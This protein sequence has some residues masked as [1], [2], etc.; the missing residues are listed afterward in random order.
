MLETLKNIFTGAETRKKILI[1]LA[2]LAVSRFLAALPCPGIDR[3]M[4]SQ[5]AAS[6]DMKALGFLNLFAGN[7][8]SNLAIGAVGITAYINASI[9]IQLL[10]AVVPYLNELTKIGKEGTD[11]IKRITFILSVAI[12]FVQGLSYSLRFRNYGVIGQSWQSAAEVTFFLTLGSV[13][14]YGISEL[15]EH[16]GIGNGVSFIIAVNIATGLYTS[17]GEIWNVFIKGQNPVRGTVNGMIAVAVV[18]A[19]MYAIIYYNDGEKRLGVTYPGSNRYTASMKTYLPIKPS[20]GNVMPPI[21]ALSFFQLLGAV[22]TVAGDHP[23]TVPFR[24]FQQS[25]WFDFSG[26]WTWLYSLGVILY[27][28]MIVG[29][30]YLYAKI[31]F[32]PQEVADNLRMQGGM[33]NGI[34]QDK[35]A[36]EIERQSSG[37]LLIGGLG[38][39]VIM[40]LPTLIAK[41]INIG[42]LAV[43]GTSLIILVS[44]ASDIASRITADAKI[45]SDRKMSFRGKGR[46]FNV[47]AD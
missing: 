33:L 6:S 37:A 29:C 10:S 40:I 16:R 26:K 8:L 4:L 23:W 9:I 17:A 30:T 1:T 27:V 44:V 47:K 38:I 11:K 15:I 3:T 19:V 20:V 24:I 22:P 36:E 18:A 43:G 14:M 39:A 31:V 42:S 34:R 25:Y 2:L 21:M 46:H 12:G 35:M 13:I 45:E 32:N 7:Q 5:W 41:I 28:L